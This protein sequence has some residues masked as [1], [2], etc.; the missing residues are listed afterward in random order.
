MSSSIPKE[1]IERAARVYHTNQLAS[2]ALGIHM[3]TFSRLCQE[4]G[5]STPYERRREQS[6]M[7]RVRSEQNQQ[8]HPFARRIRR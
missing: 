2:A 6:S 8:L 7:A 5:V 4:Y 3:G 1:Q